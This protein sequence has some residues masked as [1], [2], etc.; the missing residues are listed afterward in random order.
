M[1]H[2]GYV[3]RGVISVFADVARSNGVAWIV[4][5]A[6]HRLLRILGKSSTH[7]RYHLRRRGG[8]GHSSWQKGL[9]FGARGT[10]MANNAFERTVEH[11]GPRLAAAQRWWPVDQLGRL[12]ASMWLRRVTVALFSLSALSSIASEG[13]VYVARH[14]CN[15]SLVNEAIVRACSDASPELA[16][17]AREALATWHTKYGEKADRAATDC[18]SSL[19]EEQLQLG[20]REAVRLWMSELE[21]RA[22]MRQV[23]FCETAIAQLS[24][25][26]GS[27]DSQ[28]WK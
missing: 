12:A 26:P 18:A 23:T 17:R 1:V 14:S 24:G 16:G 27:V 3:E 15:A 22:K 5:W 4:S 10:M 7:G 6:R 8:L 2:R 9:E 19:S 28:L 13:L 11:R 21:R 20:Q 25:G